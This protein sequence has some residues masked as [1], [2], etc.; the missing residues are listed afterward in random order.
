MNRLACLIAVFCTAATTG[1]ADCKSDHVHLV[2]TG[3]QAQFSV[4][5]A[6]TPDE[7][8]QGLMNRPTLARFSGMLFVF[9]EPHIAQF[10]MKNT[11]IPLDI[12]YFDKDGRLLNIWRDAQPGEL[13]GPAS[14]GLAQYVLE[15][16]GGLA[17]TLNIQSDTQLLHPLVAGAEKTL[18][19]G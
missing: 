16:R 15:I 18:D 5:L 10:W 8:A 7:R 9:E 4:E 17:K 11:L 12:M 13:M 2:G 19:C 1:L 14:D 6:Q 3:G